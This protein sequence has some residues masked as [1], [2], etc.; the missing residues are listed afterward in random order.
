MTINVTTDKQRQI[1]DITEQIEQNIKGDGL[2][3]IFAK[4]TSAAI[5]T[6][7][8]D[9]GTDQD[10]L[11]AITAMT[12]QLQWQ[13]PHNPGHFPDHLWTSLIG[14][15]LSIP[16]QKGKLQLGT[17]QRVVLIEFNGPREREIEL[18]L[19]RF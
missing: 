12:P 8:L 1:V 2:L 5:T 10:F 11:D 19:I 9:P 3:H 14:P 15:E 18:T 4:H 6:A 17:W 7:D 16:Y 13:H